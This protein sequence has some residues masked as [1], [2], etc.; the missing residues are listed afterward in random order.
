MEAAPGAGFEWVSENKEAARAARKEMTFA[1]LPVIEAITRFD[2]EGLSGVTFSFYNRGDAGT[3]KREEFEALLARITTTVN[4][5]LGSI[6]TPRP[7]DPTSAVNAEGVFWDKADRRFLLEWSSQREI[8]GRDQPFRAEFVRLNVSP[9]PTTAS[10]ATPPRNQRAVSGATPLENVERTPEGDTRLRSVPMVDQ[11][12]K[13]YCVTA[14]VERVLRYYG[15][16][17][18][19]HELAQ[20]GNSDA[21]EG[22]SSEAMLDAL[23]KLT[24]RLG[25]RVNEF[26]DLDFKSFLGMTED[27]NRVA[28]RQKSPELNV[29]TSG[30]I[31]ISQIYGQMK[32]EILLEAR[33]KSRSDY[34]KFQREL[35]RQIDQGYPLLWSVMLGLVPE[36]PA[37]PQARGG[38]MRLIIGY[39][40]EK[41]EL[42]Y[43]D[44]WGAGHELK[45]MPMDS[46][47]AITTGLSTLVPL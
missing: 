40:T 14:S 33:M 19:Q 36:T 3:M 37:L 45:R 9:N 17:V 12:Q 24:G 21:D 35:G 10:S 31:D 28:K 46:A 39:N 15:A 32:G 22:T 25:V 43:T 7:R 47:W 6:A 29:P 5:G 20:I 1:G 38:H 23:R 2:T 44:S 34:G 27:Y 26:Y 42:L 4:T 41:N 18:D 13:G 16:S 11:G 30:M 8:K